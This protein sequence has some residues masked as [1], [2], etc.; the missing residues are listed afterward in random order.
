MAF[1][2]KSLGS[3]SVTAPQEH[4]RT[5]RLKEHMGHHCLSSPSPTFSDDGGGGGSEST[6]SLRKGVWEVKYRPVWLLTQISA[7]RSYGRLFFHA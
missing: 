3:I 6:T 1:F 5:I 4:G 2:R 7:F